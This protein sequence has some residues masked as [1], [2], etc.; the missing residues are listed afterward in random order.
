MTRQ[1]G[2]IET[3]VSRASKCKKCQTIIDKGEQAYKIVTPSTYYFLCDHC[4]SNIS[5]YSTRNDQI[6]NKPI[7]SGITLGIEHEQ[8]GNVLDYRALYVMG[9]IPTSDC[10]VNVEYKSPVYNSLRGLKLT[11]ETL[12]RAGATSGDN[13]SGTHC[14]IGTFDSRELAIIQTNA[15]QLFDRLQS[16]L[17]NDQQGTIEFFGRFFSGYCNLTSTYNGHSSWLNLYTGKPTIELRLGKFESAGQ[18]YK[19]MILA[20]FIGQILKSFLDGKIS[21]SKA[22]N[23]FI[24]IYR[25]CRLARDVSDIIGNNNRA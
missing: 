17:L 7:K 16:H 15:C 8:A 25:K 20:R 22:S 6:N 14:H 24:V 23:K 11:L 3:A 19:V 13:R 21:A 12:E 18:Y 2:T 1:P 9:W 4:H 5:A 10:T